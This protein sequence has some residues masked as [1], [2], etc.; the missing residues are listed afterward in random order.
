MIATV[1]RG[2]SDCAL[3]GS[4]NSEVIRI[5]TA[6]RTTRFKMFDD[7]IARNSWFQV[8]TGRESNVLGSTE[9]YN[10]VDAAN[11]GIVAEGSSEVKECFWG[12]PWYLGLILSVSCT[13]ELS[14]GADRRQA[15]RLYLGS[16]SVPFAVANGQQLP[17]R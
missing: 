12:G 9:N 13:V 15:E 8:G 11:E 2:V 7:R 4:G 3:A 6:N 16:Y 10:A 5:T 17:G 14:C 1:W